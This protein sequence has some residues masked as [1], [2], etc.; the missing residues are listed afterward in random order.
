MSDQQ[1]PAPAGIDAEAIKGMMRD[2]MQEM[3]AKAAPINA[4]DAEPAPRS[5][6]ASKGVSIKRHTDLGFG[7]DAIKSFEWYLR[8]GDN[9]AYKANVAPINSSTTNEGEENVPDML[10]NQ[11]VAKR[12]EGSIARRAGV[13]VIQ[14]NTDY[15]RIS[16]EGTSQTVFAITSEESAVDEDEPG[17]AAVNVP[18]YEF[19]KL[20]KVTRR[21]LEDQQ[22]NLLAFLNDS[23]ARAMA[24]TENKYV[25]TGAGTTEP[26]GI[27]AGGTKR[28][29]FDSATVIGKSEIPELYYSLAPEYAEN[30]VWMTNYAVEGEIFSLNDDKN[31]SFIQQA[32][33]TPAGKTLWGRPI[34]N[35]SQMTGTVAN[36]KSLVIGDMFFYGLVERMGLSVQRLDELYAANGYVGFIYR[37]RMGGA[38]LQPEAFAYGQHPSA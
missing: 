32:P 35:T 4:E 9:A 22:T 21:Q 7:D 11:I 2:V 3:A 26:Q 8:T 10:Y 23:V 38:V 19:T 27:L 37:F 25:I 5:G 34:F 31:W 18:V 33:G 1:N 16:T 17:F 15:V 36:S 12:D 14:T 24:A 6:I 20:V 29:D 13:R 30:S 28:V